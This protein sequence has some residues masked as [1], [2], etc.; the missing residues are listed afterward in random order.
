MPIIEFEKMA[1]VINDL[2]V[3]AGEVE[4]ICPLPKVAV[5]HWFC[6][7][8]LVASSARRETPLKSMRYGVLVGIYLL[9]SGW[10]Q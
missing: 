2:R 8:V 7:Q 1:F 9:C 4:T 6:T 3:G 5:V 10:C